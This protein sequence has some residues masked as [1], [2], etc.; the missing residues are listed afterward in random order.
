[1]QSTREMLAKLRDADFDAEERKEEFEALQAQLAG[2]LTK[3]ADAEKASGKLQEEVAAQAKQQQ[4]L[5][6]ELSLAQVC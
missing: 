2:S 1:M 6:D 4:H 3:L 5:L